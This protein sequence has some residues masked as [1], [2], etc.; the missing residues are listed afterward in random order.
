MAFK[1]RHNFIC[2][3]SYNLR[4]FSSVFLH[5][6]SGF[7]FIDS[8]NDDFKSAVLVFKTCAVVKYAS[9]LSFASIVVGSFDEEFKSAVLVFKLNV[10]EKYAKGLFSRSVLV[11]FFWWRFKISS[12]VIQKHTL[13]R[14]AHYSCCLLQ[15]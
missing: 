2:T 13:W 8:C 10:V 11:I 7:V 9:F 1:F 3:C 12:S 5:I 15:L 14:N 4:I 6:F